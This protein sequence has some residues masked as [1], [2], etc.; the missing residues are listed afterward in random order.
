MLFKNARLILP[1]RIQPAASLRVRDGRIA[2]ISKPSET[3]SVEPGEA[4][5]DARGKFLSPGFLDMHIHGA[6]RRDTMEATP[7]AF[8]EIC[9]FH[10]SGGTTSLALTTVSAPQNEIIKVLNAIGAIDPNSTGGARIVG[11]HIE[12]PYFS[13]EK[14]G[15]H[16]PELLRNPD[17][18]EYTEWLQY[19]DRITQ[20]TLAPEL[21]GALD[22]IE[23]L[24]AAGIRVSGGHSDA[25]DEEAAA[26]FAHGMR[27]ATHT[28]NCMSSARRKGAYR[29]AGLLEFAMGEPEML[30]E[31]I[32]DCHH[33]SPTLMRALYHAKGADGIALV[34]D[35][36]GGAGLGVGE[37]FMVGCIKAV[38]HEG[39]SLTEDGSALACSVARMHQLV[40]NMV[41]KVG[42]PLQEAVRMASLNPA[43]ALGLDH[44]LGAIETGLK[45]DL[46]LLDDNLETEMT[47]LEGQRIF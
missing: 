44:V 27:Q 8:S 24:C 5:L 26:G 23:A 30:C 32:A 47:F 19:R 29:V 9:R 33:V 31:L 14:P 22:C 20:V 38:V 3:L 13:K 15:A 45:A 40:R 28:F 6:L 37:S 42:V 17:P 11:V 21:P 46:V 10:A 39:I 41:E 1:D 4:V 34:T 18:I 36:G 2:E 12:G 7:E 16:L 43:R 35:A 25:W